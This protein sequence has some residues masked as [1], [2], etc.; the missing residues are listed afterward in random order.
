[1][2]KLNDDK[3]TNSVYICTYVY[4]Y[5]YKFEI[6]YTQV[7]LLDTYINKHSDIPFVSFILISL[8]QL[9]TTNCYIIE[10]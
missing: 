2:C 6:K 5:V 4:A 1:M 10:Y 7:Y 8:N 3:S 9:H